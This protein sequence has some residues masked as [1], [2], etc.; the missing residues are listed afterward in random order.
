MLLNWRRSTLSIVGVVFALA[1][2]GLPLSR[3]EREFAGVSHLIGYEAIWCSIVIV[4][5]LYIRLVEVRPL[6]SIGFRLPRLSDLFIGFGAGVITLLGLAGI[7]YVIFPT[8]HFNERS[9]V[10]QLLATPLWWRC[11][12]VVRA[13]VGEEVLFR[14]YAIERGQELIRSVTAA[15][16]LSWFVFTI[17][18]VGTWGWT[19]VI[20]AGFGGLVLT[21]LYVWRRN[22]WTNILA[23]LIVDGVAVLVS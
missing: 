8:L 18:H 4:L 14:G 20:P 23:H 3:W 12:S 19:H 22:L 11:V 10:N 2:P 16:V 1:I 5:L 6:S 13:A 17:E 21:V 15:S 9:Q 7:F